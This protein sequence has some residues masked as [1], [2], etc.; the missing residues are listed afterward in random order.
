MRLNCVNN[1]GARLVGATKTCEDY[2][3]RDQRAYKLH[4]ERCNEF[5]FEFHSST[6]WR[7][8]VDQ[9]WRSK[10]RAPK[11]ASRPPDGLVL[12]LLSVPSQSGKG[13]P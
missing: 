7:G 8:A 6:P 4:M 5:E 9:D 12:A 2:M 10:T 11:R 13:A 1:F 3:C